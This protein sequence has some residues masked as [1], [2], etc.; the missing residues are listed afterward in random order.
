MLERCE[1]IPLGAEVEGRSSIAG[2]FL[3]KKWENALL[4]PCRSLIEVEDNSI[5]Q[6]A[7]PEDSAERFS[8]SLRRPGWAEQDDLPGLIEAHLKRREERRGARRGALEPRRCGAEELLR[9]LEIICLTRELVEAEEIE[10]G[11]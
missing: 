8:S 4:P 9:A 5:G 7:L 2:E 6:V 3:F 11:E 1:A 10:R